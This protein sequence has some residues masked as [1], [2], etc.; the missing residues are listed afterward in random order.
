M[1]KDARWKLLKG[2]SVLQKYVNRSPEAIG[3]EDAAEAAELL[4]LRPAGVAVRRRP[5][6]P[7]RV[8][9]TTPLLLFGRSMIIFS[10]EF[11]GN[12]SFAGLYGKLNFLSTAFVG[13]LRP[14]TV[15]TLPLG[16]SQ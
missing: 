7:R 12:T 3:I 9:L 13:T 10:P 16:R 5:P 15:G 8:V 11:N 4:R 6:T 2:E 1:V 14:L